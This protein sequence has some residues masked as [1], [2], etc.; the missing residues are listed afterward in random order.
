MANDI[1]LNR[2]TPP[3]DQF[4][5]VTLR[6]LDE[7]P[8]ASALI[9]WYRS[10]LHQLV[11]VNL[12]EGTPDFAF[13]PAPLTREE[14][15]TLVNRLATTDHHLDIAART[16]E[17]HQAESEPFGPKSSISAAGYDLGDGKWLSVL[18]GTLDWRATLNA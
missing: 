11:V 16:P 5:L 13:T 2:L 14:T 4:T 1:A 10:H 12:L 8:D 7:Q 17:I 3:G 18:I 9:N 6:V 15:A